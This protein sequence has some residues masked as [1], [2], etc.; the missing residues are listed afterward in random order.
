VAES[1]SR[2]IAGDMATGNFDPTLVK[3]KPQIL[4]EEIG[5]TAIFQA[6]EKAR[7][8]DLELATRQK[9]QAIAKHLQKHFG[10]KKAEAV[11]AKDA[12]KF[13]DWL[14]TFQEPVTVR[15]RITVLCACWKW[16]IATGKLTENP[17][18]QIKVRVEKRTP[19]P[20]T[21][22][23]IQ[24]IIKA[25]EDDRYYAH[26]TKYVKFLVATGCRTG[27]A[28]GLRWKN[29]SENC[30][31][32]DIVERL[33]ND[34]QWKDTKNH[35]VRSLALT[36]KLQ[37]LL[38]KHRPQDWKPDDLVFPSPEGGAIHPNN[39]RRRAWTTILKKADVPYRKPYNSRH[40]A[41][42][43]AISRGV[44]PARVA[45]MAG[46]RLETVLRNYVGNVDG[47]PETLDF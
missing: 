41:L 24:R 21:D 16:A 25:F 8:L 4:S 42:S 47:M 28:I 31:R 35:R 14:L 33:G 3:Y 22:D 37:E 30:D 32:V 18:E 10:I 40:T 38:L 36:P 45:E 39:F 11:T 7:S 9:Y 1:K 6:Y 15:D 43:H 23:E 27:E 20:F 46:D 13:R 2:Q 12:E 44:S 17:W 5:V 29:V 19:N 26:Y 34:K